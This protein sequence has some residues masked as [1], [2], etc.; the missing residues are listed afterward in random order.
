MPLSGVVVLACRSYNEF[1]QCGAFNIM[2]PTQYGNPH[3][4]TPKQDPKEQQP[5]QD[6]FLNGT[7]LLLAPSSARSNVA[8]GG[9]TA[10]SR[11][12][13]GPH[14]ADD[15]GQRQRMGL[16]I[17]I[18]FL[19]WGPYEGSSSFGS[20]LGAPD[21]LETSNWRLEQAVCSKLKGAA[22]PI[23]LSLEVPQITSEATWSPLVCCGLE[24][25]A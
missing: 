2:D 5:K 8:R 21:V 19:F 10:L 9:K 12:C 4:Q 20:M 25:S 22:R 18:G 15:G 11:G 23:E 14:A 24:T 17:D 6:P 1:Q 7:R 16:F 3:I 13:G